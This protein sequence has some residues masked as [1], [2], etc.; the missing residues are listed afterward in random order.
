MPEFFSLRVVASGSQAVF[1][2]R[3]LP[4]NEL[5]AW[6]HRQE[7]RTVRISFHHHDKCH[8]S[9]SVMIGGAHPAREGYGSEVGSH[10]DI[11]D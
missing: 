1:R 4:L 11:R 8:G 3:R 2:E 6:D 10:E 5:P 7:G 9:V